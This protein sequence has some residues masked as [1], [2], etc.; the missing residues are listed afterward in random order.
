MFF[1]IAF[2]ASGALG[3]LIAFTQLIAAL[4]NPARSSEVP[5]ILTNLGIDIGAVYLCI[6]V[7]QG[8]HC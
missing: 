8:E 6:S 2:I 7:F 1:Y 3:G 5:D 4:N